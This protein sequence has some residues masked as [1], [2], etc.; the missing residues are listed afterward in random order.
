MKIRI[1][2]NGRC[3]RA[4]SVIISHGKRRYPEFVL[5][6]GFSDNAGQK[7]WDTFAKT[8]QIRAFPLHSLYA[9]LI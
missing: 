3:D 4:I 1:I 2:A 5:K 7:S 8:P 9:M 6:G